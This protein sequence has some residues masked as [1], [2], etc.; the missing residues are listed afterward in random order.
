MDTIEITIPSHP[1]YLKV[2]RC[3]VERLC[4]L[5]PLT[6]EGVAGVIQAVNEAVTNII[7]HAYENAPDKP[8]SL[9]C[10]LLPDALEIVLHDSGKSTDPENLRSREL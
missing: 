8:I 5:S 2:V 1:K 10:R 7:R 6:K 9:R 4:Q 3:G